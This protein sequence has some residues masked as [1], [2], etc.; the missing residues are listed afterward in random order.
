MSS[1]ESQYPS[2]KR[3]TGGMPKPVI[4]GRGPGCGW[5]AREIRKDFRFSW[6]IPR[7][8][9]PIWYMPSASAMLVSGRLMNHTSF[10]MWLLLLDCRGAQDAGQ[11][12]GSHMGAAAQAQV[13]TSEPYIVRVQVKT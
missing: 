4:S 3:N 13:E 5:S 9:W 8:T 6:R 2:E 12:S 7:R 10:T 1:K 11:P